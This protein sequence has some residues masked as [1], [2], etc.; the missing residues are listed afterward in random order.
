MNSLASEI[1]M[2]LRF[3]CSV[4]SVNMHIILSMGKNPKTFS[5]TVSVCYV[6]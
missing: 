2:I 3:L 6:L 5:G 1:Q 4:K